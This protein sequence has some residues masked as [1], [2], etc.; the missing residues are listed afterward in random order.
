MFCCRRK[1]KR[2][3]DIVEPVARPLLPLIVTV[4]TADEMQAART[5]NL[6]ED[7]MVAQ[8]GFKAAQDNLCAAITQSV[9]KN[10]EHSK[11]YESYIKS[12]RKSGASEE[13]RR[14]AY[15]DFWLW[16]EN[17]QMLH[18]KFVESTD[19]TLRTTATET[20]QLE[21]FAAAKNKRDRAALLVDIC[22]RFWRRVQQ[23]I[24]H[25]LAH[26]PCDK[27]EK[28]LQ[29]KVINYLACGPN[30]FDYSPDVDWSSG[31]TTHGE[32]TEHVED[33]CQGCGFDFPHS[34]GTE[35]IMGF[36]IVLQPPSRN[37]AMIVYELKNWT[38]L[39][40]V[41][42]DSTGIEF[43]SVCRTCIHAIRR[44]VDEQQVVYNVI[45]EEL[46][47]V[48]CLESNLA[49]LASTWLFSSAC[50]ACESINPKLPNYYS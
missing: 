50:L 28:H 17:H 8:S 31:C 44:R 21:Q 34:G 14:G 5:K 1:R 10:K 11:L 49:V 43:F 41:S 3:Q 42:V 9:G 40:Q 37:P 18:R 23:F 2:H 6:E 33:F 20:H 25:R 35:I 16:R 12:A 26:V 15:E 27:N 38:G 29:E 13:V 19:E 36:S 30:I 45:L 22:H 24:N 7:L 32:Q 46:R 48:L 4:P 47:R 39:S